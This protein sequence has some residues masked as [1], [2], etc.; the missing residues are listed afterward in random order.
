VDTGI[1]ELVLY[2]D[3]LRRNLPQLKLSSVIGNAHSGPLTG[4]RAA[5]DGLQLDDSHRDFHTFLLEEAPE[6]L[7]AD[8]DG[9]IGVAVLHAVWVELDFKAQTL[10][11]QPISSVSTTQRIP[12]P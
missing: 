7:P 4:S 9:Y 12:G 6:N 5:L 11:W 3:R 10:R 2:S 1:E 8:I